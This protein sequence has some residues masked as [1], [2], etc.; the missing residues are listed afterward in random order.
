M[1]PAPPPPLT[2]TN[3]RRMGNTIMVGAVVKAKIGDLEKDIREGF[4]RRLR[5]DM[6]CVV[7]EIVGKM[8]YSVRIQDG[9][10][11]EMSLNHIAIEDRGEGGIYDS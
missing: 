2:Y 7:K 6:T 8:R 1:I 4:L 11:N 9:L 3:K 10:E 5:K